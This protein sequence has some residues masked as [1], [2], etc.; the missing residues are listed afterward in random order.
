MLYT[1]RRGI[2][3]YV[4]IGPPESCALHAIQQIENKANYILEFNRFLHMGNC[5]DKTTLKKLIHIR[6][7]ELVQD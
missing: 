5:A 1:I 3:S 2:K 6:R 7:H 4:I